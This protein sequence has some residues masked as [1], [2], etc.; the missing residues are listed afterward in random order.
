MNEHR[1][2]KIVSAKELLCGFLELRSL[3]PD[4]TKWTEAGFADNPPRL[5]RLQRLKS[6][7]K[8]FKIAW[9]TQSFINGG[10]INHKNAKYKLLWQELDSALPSIPAGYP[11][12]KSTA[13]E[14]PNCFEI[15][16]SYRE[17][18]ESVL[19]FSD[20]TL[21]ASGLFKYAHRKIK[22]INRGIAKIIA[23]I[24]D[25]LSSF[26][27]PEGRTFTID[28][29]VKDYGYPDV[30]LNTIDMDFM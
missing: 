13:D 11:F 18:V 26:I 21:A 8:A 20:G 23:S 4:M 24:D 6:L 7:F 25:L 19:V 9:D 2:K 28:K 1:D 15:L 3:A 16:L 10:F 14:L 30:D 29:L 27:S 12:H 22:S 5:Y 17:R